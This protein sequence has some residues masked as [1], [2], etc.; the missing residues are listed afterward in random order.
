MKNYK[1][2]YASLTNDINDQNNKKQEIEITLKNLKKEQKIITLK[3]TELID[4]IKDLKEERKKVINQKISPIIITAN[5]ILVAL[6][7]AAIYLETAIVS[8][9][10]TVGKRILAS[11]GLFIGFGNIY[12]CALIGVLVGRDTIIK[13][14]QNKNKDNERY[15]ELTKKMK[16]K[17][18][19][20]AKIKEEK[21]I[22]TEKIEVKE[23]ENKEIIKQLD[24]ST[25]ELENLK[26]EIINLITNQ[27]REN[28]NNIVEIEET[29]PY[30]RTKTKEN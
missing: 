27:N 25:Q 17:N 19:E 7:I 10:A 12:M 28:I 16:E 9:I 13:K 11:I 21:Q 2:I 20:L 24:L 18:K 15:I 5:T 3:E 8:T 22:I 1:E 26:N 29:K 4:D 14:I 6:L 30:T 23:S